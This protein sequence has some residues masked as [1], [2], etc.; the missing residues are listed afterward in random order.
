V[1]WAH[2]ADVHWYDRIVA[3]GAYRALTGAVIGTTIG[4]AGGW[5]AAR[6]PL[7]RSKQRQELIIDLLDTNKPG[8]LTDLLTAIQQLEL[9]RD[10]THPGGN[11]EKP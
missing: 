11:S 8:G 4:I 2:W 9:Q 10:A 7:K 5:L 6:L 1:S 3:L